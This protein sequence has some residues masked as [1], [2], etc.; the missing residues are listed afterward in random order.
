MTAWWFLW[1]FWKL[2]EQ[3]AFIGILDMR[4]QSERPFRLG[5][6]ENHVKQAEEFEIRGLV[7]GTSLQQCP[8]RAE[9][10]FY[11]GQGVGNDEGP[12]RGPQMMTTSKG[13]QRMSRW[14]PTPRYPPMTQLATMM[15]PI[16]TNMPAER[17]ENCCYRNQLSWN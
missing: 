11:N 6:L 12:Q 4:L 17:T 15:A 8:D 13:C 3:F 9:A 7:V 14:P 1:E 16:I 5:Q 10:S 2:R